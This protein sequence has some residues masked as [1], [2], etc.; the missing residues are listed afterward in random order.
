M[1]REWQKAL[2]PLGKKVD[3]GLAIKSHWR[4]LDL[5]YLTTHTPRSTTRQWGRMQNA[6]RATLKAVIISE[7]VRK[8]E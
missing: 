7:D 6:D 4:V 3:A 2:Q 5:S 8:R 1:I